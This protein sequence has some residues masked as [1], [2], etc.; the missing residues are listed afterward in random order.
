MY[1]KMKTG[2]RIGEM[3][4]VRF[5]AAKSLIE[6]GLAEKVDFDVRDNQPMMREAQGEEALHFMNETKLANIEL[7]DE[8][9]RPNRGA[10]AIAKKRR[11][12]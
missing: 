3:Q 2:P 7:G 5:D 10:G 12:I 4:D 1:I 9:I 6:Q 8:V 11:K